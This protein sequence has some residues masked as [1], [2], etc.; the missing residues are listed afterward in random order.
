MFVSKHASDSSIIKSIAL[1]SPHDVPGFWGEDLWLQRKAFV[2][3]VKNY[4]MEFLL[5]RIENNFIAPTTTDLK[6]KLSS[7]KLDTDDNPLT[8]L[9]LICCVLLKIN[10]E[11]GDYYR[12]K[13]AILNKESHFTIGYL[14]IENILD[15]ID[16]LIQK[17]KQ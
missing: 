3:C 17:R 12:I 4:G 11:L 5:E 2:H 13:E 15:L 6:T 14:Y 7:G 16:A 9:E 1:K 10:F 8:R